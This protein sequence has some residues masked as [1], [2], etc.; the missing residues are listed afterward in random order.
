MSGGRGFTKLITKIIKNNLHMS[1]KLYIMSH[2][3]L[4]KFYKRTKI[5]YH[6]LKNGAEGHYPHPPNFWLE[7][8]TFQ[9]KCIFPSVA[10]N[11]E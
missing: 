6:T 2:I 1:V 5:N 7:T 8:L 3:I 9:C 10:L 4:C 11:S